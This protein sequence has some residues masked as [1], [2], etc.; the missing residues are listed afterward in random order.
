MVIQ[1]NRRLTPEARQSF[2]DTLH[3]YPGISGVAASSD[4]PFSGS[5]NVNS[6]TI[7][8][9]SGTLTTEQLL[10]TPEF[11]DL[12]GMKLAAGRALT[13]ERAE[14]AVINRPDAKNDGHN[15]L[16]NETAARYF[17]FGVQG[18]VGKTVIIDKAALHIVGVLKD[19]RFK[20]ARQAVQPTF[21]DNDKLDSTTLSVRLTG[22][23]MPGAIAFIDRTWHRMAPSTAITRSF[24]DDTF[25]KL[26]QADQ[27]QGTMFGIFVGV[28]IGIAALGLFGLA[29]F[30]VGRR[31]K[32]IGIRK[33]FGARTR[34]VV[35][36]LLWQFSI[37]VLIANVI[38]W[39][40]AWY[41]LRG[42]LQGFA[43]HI[44]LSP[45]YFAAA[46]LAALLIAW[47]TVLSHALRVAG[48][49]PI[50]ALRTE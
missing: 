48:A 35:I 1:T 18:A 37:P 3:A 39:P 49:N 23:D 45:L 7:P 34:D 27:K 46:G 16:I 17:G 33:V 25:E 28:A 2:M 31:T 32:E 22:Q 10:I 38:A 26:Y 13:D 50:H 21:Y 6:I 4:T 42:W 8:G 19:F 44:A 20:G 11:I 5:V 30:T 29:A 40:L 43:S 12:Y 36:L 24:L 41:Y 14:D 47:A 15:I 9:Q